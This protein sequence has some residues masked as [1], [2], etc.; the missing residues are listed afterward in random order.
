M[1]LGGNQKLKVYFSEFDLLE[2]LPQN[3]YKTLAADYYRKQLKAQV[4]GEAFLEDRPNYVEGK[5]I[6][7]E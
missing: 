5:T 2:E 3:R 7:V 6:I 4:L 1:S